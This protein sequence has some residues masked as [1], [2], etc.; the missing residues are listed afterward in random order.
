MNQIKFYIIEI[1][2]TRW[3]DNRL[4]EMIGVDAEDAIECCLMDYPDAGIEHIYEE[5]KL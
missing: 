3:K 5:I 2:R 1:S 4:I